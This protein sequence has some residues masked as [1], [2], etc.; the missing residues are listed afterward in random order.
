MSRVAAVH[1]LS[2]FKHL[3]S[4]VQ[5]ALP[6]IKV[7]D[8]EP[9]LTSDPENTVAKKQ[10]S[11]IEVLLAEPLLAKRY[12]HLFSSL[13]WFQSTFAGVETLTDI[14]PNNPPKFL[15]TRSG[16]GFGH[17][18]TDY[19]IGYIIAKE[20][21]FFDMK[22]SQG[23]C[24]WDANKY[25]TLFVTSQLNIGILGVGEIGKHIAKTCK[26]LGMTTWGLVRSNTEERKTQYPEVD[27]LCTTSNLEHLLSN[28]DYI[29]NILPST[30]DTRGLL[31]GD[32]LAACKNRKT[33]FINVG[34]GDVIDDD[35]LVN[36]L[37]SKWLDGAILDVF[38]T[39]PLPL[40]SL[41]WKM[42]NVIITPHIAG[43][44]V[45]S[46]VCKIF[47]ENFELFS[48]GKK[49]KFEVDWLKAY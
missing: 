1:I 48:E 47:Q 49:L 22:E 42:P 14:D 5:N 25:S 17:S 27:H 40:D 24:S 34:R 35:S 43:L 10:L 21:C 29:C 41:L 9:L 12:F 39:E 7:I 23:N 19:V 32:V 37:R 2:E 11:E 36:A 33:T 3:H 38:N 26:F 6:N 46:V 30:K 20:R 45:P 28:C 18:I 15:L 44:S 31:S 13:K 16:E 8:V 4:L